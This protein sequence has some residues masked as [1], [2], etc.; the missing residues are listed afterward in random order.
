[1][2]VESSGQQR[3]VLENCVR[4]ATLAPSLHNSQPWRFRISDGVVDVFADPGRRLDVL[5]PGGR[6]LMISVGAAV[7]TLRLRILAD[8]LRP[9]VAYFPDAERPDLVARVTTGE[10]VAAPDETLRLAAAIEHR[11]TNRQPF[12]RATI[13][14]D[15]LDALRAAAVAEDA[16]LTVANP[17]SRNAIIALSQVADRRLRAAG[18][19]RAELARWTTHRQ[20]HRDGVPHTAAGPWDALETM[21]IRDFGLL[22]PAPARPTEAFEPYPVIMVLATAGDDR[23]AWLAAGQ[24]LQRV[25][26][27][28]TWHNLATTPISQPVEIPAIREQLTDTG[29]G[30]WAQMVLRAGYGRPTVA[31]PRRPLGDVIDV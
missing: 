9:S 11:H 27:T 16:T 13:P 28:A 10:P 2:I 15:V 22:R 21:P 23:A 4:A 26:L 24:A 30:V 17:V 6:E 25:L 19:Y 7:F 14:A 5:D 31:T 29:A 1:M 12:A 18:G 3:V 20:P 8:G